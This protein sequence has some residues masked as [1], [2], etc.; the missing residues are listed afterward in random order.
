MD[1]QRKRRER[2]FTLIELLVVIAIIAV[3]VSLLLPAVQQAR[4]AARRTQCKNNLHQIALAVL[5]YESAFGS[6]P[7]G[8]NVPWCGFGG[9][10]NTSA[11]DASIAVIPGNGQFGPNWAVAILPF[12]EQ[13]ALYDSANLQSYPGVFVDPAIVQSGSGQAP[14]GVNY[15]SWRLGL[16]GRTMPAYLC[17]SDAFNAVPFSN[18]SVPGDVDG[19]WA[20]GN[21]GATAGYDDYDHVNRGATFKSSKSNVAG[22][23]GLISSAVFAC[24]Y[25]AKIKDI[26]DGMS[27][28]RMIGELRAG[29][30]SNDPRGVWALGFP[31]ASI[32]NGGRGTYNPSPNNM[33]G[34]LGYASCS[35]TD[36]GDELQFSCATEYLGGYC[37]PATAALGMGCNG[38]GTLMTSAQSRSLHA[39]GVNTAMCDGSVQFISNYID[40]VN[41]CRLS[42]KGD[43]Q[44]ITTGGF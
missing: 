1:V 31:G 26:R 30:T 10:N 17:P 21:Y 13:N 43:G 36:G 14:S 15:T 7:M 5:N 29:L 28:T 38:G 16:V 27:N 40:E 32:Q 9:D 12:I 35:N 20:R 4:E 24:S 25:G 22:K 44:I 23:N 6:F 39:G 34:G 18:P 41:W 33:I 3:L 42:S 8:S 11:L 2:G 37:S 19:T